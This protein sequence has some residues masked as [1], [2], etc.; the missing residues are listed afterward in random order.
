VAVL[1]VGCAREGDVH[2][3]VRH[4]LR[5]AAVCRRVHDLAGLSCL[6]PFETFMTAF[7]PQITGNLSCATSLE[8]DAMKNRFRVSLA[9][10]VIEKLFLKLFE[11]VW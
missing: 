2:K 1:R 6:N 10:Y 11:S 5:V 3:G 9:T 4:Q 8:V 7:Y